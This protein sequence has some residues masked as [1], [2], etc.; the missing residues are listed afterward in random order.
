MKW[1]TR[2]PHLEVERSKIKVARPIIA[3][4][5]KCH[6]FSKGRSTTFKLG[7]GTAMEYDDPRHRHAS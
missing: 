6:I 5:E 2:D 7:T 1:V 3:E 4:M